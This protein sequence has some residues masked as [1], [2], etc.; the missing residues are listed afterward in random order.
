MWAPTDTDKKAIIFFIF[1]LWGGL[2]HYISIVKGKEKVFSTF[3]LVGD[4]VISGFSGMVAFAICQHLEMGPYLTGAIVG[5]SGH[6]GSRSTFLIE[7]YITNR[8]FEKETQNKLKK[9][10][11]S[12]KQKVRNIRRLPRLTSKY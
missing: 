8:Y 1:A 5:I 3:E 7:K 11:K 6:M 12:K 10:K 2:S 9:S 4:L